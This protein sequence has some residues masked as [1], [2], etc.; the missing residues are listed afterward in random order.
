MSNQDKDFGR[1]PNTNVPEKICLHPESTAA[2]DKPIVEA[3]K[4]KNKRRWPRHA[5][6]ILVQVRVTTHGPTRTVACDGHGTDLNGGGLA[7]IA[8]IDLL[9][10]AQ[11]KVAFTPP[12]SEQPMTFRCFVRDRIGNRY[13]VE[14]I[15]ENDEDYRNIAELQQR[16]AVMQK[17]VSP[18]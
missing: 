5:V 7:V 11:V 9:V 2:P 4:Y 1:A 18:R 10:G 3:A 8:D 12:Y 14:F 16:L 17:Q 13:G 6:D 15:T